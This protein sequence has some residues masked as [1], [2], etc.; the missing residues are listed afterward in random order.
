[1]EK[2]EKRRIPIRLIINKK[3]TIPFPQRGDPFSLATTFPANTVKKKQRSA[4][5]FE[6]RKK[7]AK[8]TTPLPATR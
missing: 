8:N 2:I 6:K 7:S 5:S 3:G 1:M 4:S